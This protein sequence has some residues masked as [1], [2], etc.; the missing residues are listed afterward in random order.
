[1]RKNRF[2]F[3]LVCRSFVYQFLTRIIDVW[4]FQIVVF[5]WK[6][7]QKYVFMEIVFSELRDGFLSFF[8]GLGSGFSD[9]F[10]L[11]SRLESRRI[12]VMKTDPCNWI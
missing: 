11:E 3:K 7:L 4:D 1:M 8:E 12:F 9:S 6:V 5:A 2:I 10:S